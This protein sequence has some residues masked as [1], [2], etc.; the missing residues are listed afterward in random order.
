MK[1]LIIEKIILKIPSGEGSATELCVVIWATKRSSRLQWK[2]T[3]FISQ[4]F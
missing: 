4:L 2:E 3:T 1:I